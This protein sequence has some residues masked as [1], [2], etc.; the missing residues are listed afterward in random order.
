MKKNVKN[1][2]EMK[3]EWID[4]YCLNKKGVSKDFKIEWEASRFMIDEKMFVMI[5][6]DKAKTE[7]ISLK[8]NPDYGLLL[9]SEYKDI[10]PGYYLNKDHWNSI[11]LNGDV[12]DDLLKELI[13]QSY[14]LVLNGFSKKRQEEITNLSS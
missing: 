8:L 9:R 10:K 5:G 13:D 14:Q 1:G 12:P 6:S 2:D 7:I 3:Y 4:E 11:N